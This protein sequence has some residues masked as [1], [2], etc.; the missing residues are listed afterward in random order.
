MKSACI[1][2][3]IRCGQAW[4]IAKKLRGEQTTTSKKIRL[5]V[6]RVNL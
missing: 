2:N 3:A 6:I 5:A 4:N 1:Q